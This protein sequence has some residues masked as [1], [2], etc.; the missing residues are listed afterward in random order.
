MFDE[1]EK[2]IIGELLD[3]NSDGLERLAEEEPAKEERSRFTALKNRIKSWFSSEEK[4][5]RI[6][7]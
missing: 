2:E 5:G 1:E 4:V 3:E 7:A 6:T